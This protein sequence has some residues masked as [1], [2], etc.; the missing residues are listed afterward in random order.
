MA[1][2]E[3]LMSYPD[4]MVA[5]MLG[6]RL[7]TL[8]RWM[9]ELDFA[10]AMRS[11]ERE[12]T[13]SLSRLARQAAVRAAAALCQAVGNGS[14]PDAKVLLDMLKVSGAFEAQEADPAETLREIVRLAEQAAEAEDEPQAQY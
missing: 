4:A 6:V 9:Q 12:Q 1:A 3:L 8:T 7:Q 14:T 10:E 11:R 2:V 5:E 13:R